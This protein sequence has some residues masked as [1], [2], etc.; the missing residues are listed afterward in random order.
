MDIHR[1]LNTLDIIISRLKLLTAFCLRRF[2]RAMFNSACNPVVTAPF[3]KS[4][5]IQCQPSPRKCTN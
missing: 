4:S 1:K 5:F 3:K 2:I